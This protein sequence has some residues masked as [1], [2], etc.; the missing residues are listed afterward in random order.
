VLSLNLSAIDTRGRRK[1]A[2]ARHVLAYDWYG[3][4]FVRGSKRD[5]ELWLEVRDV[6][7]F[8]LPAGGTVLSA[9][10]D[11]SVDSDAVLD[12]Y[13]GTALPL[14][15]QTTHGLEV[16]HGSAVLVPSHG[17]VVAFCGASQSGKSTAAY[18]LAARGYSHW[19]DDAVAFRVDGTHSV[20]AIGLPFTVKLRDGASAYFR[21]RGVDLG[22]GAGRLEI[23]GDFE[24][25]PFRF[26]A[27]FLLEPIDGERSAAIEVERLAPGQ[28]LHALLPS[29]YEDRFQPQARERRRQTLRAYLEL[30]AS[31]P[32]LT[33]RW[34]RDFERLAE[35][36]DEVERSLAEVV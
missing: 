3:V 16:L 34:S 24:W 4:P 27:V 18:A 10:P 7:T 19:A 23:V 35:L 33:V 6:A 21:A 1:S 22:P 29:A 17:C 9:V 36:L 2:L 25:R 12:A 26:G 5:G 15:L 30:V 8:H 31:V 14:V 13:Y 28:A 11:E 32:V 20:T